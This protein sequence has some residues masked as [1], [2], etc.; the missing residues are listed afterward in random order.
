MNHNPEYHIDAR[1]MQEIR[2]LSRCQWCGKEYIMVL[3]HRS[4]CG[5][6]NLKALYPPDGIKPKKNWL[7]R[8]FS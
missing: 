6:C 4:Q 7:Q 5:E 8:I 2:I 3:K 1:G